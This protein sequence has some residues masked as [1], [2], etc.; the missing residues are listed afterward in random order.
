MLALG[1]AWRALVI[2]GFAMLLCSL[3]LSGALWI[4][5]GQVKD[6]ALAFEDAF[7]PSPYPMTP[8]PSPPPG[9]VEDEALAFEDAFEALWCVFWIV[10]TLGY[11]GRFG[12]GG[13]IGQCIIALAII[14]GII[15][16]TMPITFIGEAFSSAWH[17]R[18]LLLLEMRVQDELMR[19]GIS[20]HD[21]R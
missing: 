4:A 21:F 16:T 2:P 20:V 3:I 1:S 15:L 5:E 14:C 19:R 7:D 11:E 17:R 9:Q 8:T 6:E 18:E 13:A 10:T 12:T